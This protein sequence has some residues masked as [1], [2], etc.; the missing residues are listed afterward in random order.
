M[1]KFGQFRQRI[2]AP[3][4]VED[5]ELQAWLQRVADE[6]NIL[7][8]MSTFSGTTPESVVSGNPGELAVNQAAPTASTVSRLW[9][10]QSGIG[11]TGWSSVVTG[12]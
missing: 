9:V 4:A 1:T 5:R 7:P 10:K 8:A 11:N 3:P 6:L 2:G 12:T